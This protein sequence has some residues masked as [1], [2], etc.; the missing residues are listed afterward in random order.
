MP[1]KKVDPEETRTLHVTTKREE[2]RITIPASCKVTFGPIFTS[3][4]RRNNSYSE[5]GAPTALRIYEA[6][7]KQRAVF[8]DV[9]TFRDLSY[10]L[11]RKVA[12][13]KERAVWE[14]DGRGFRQERSGTRVDKWLPAGP[15]EEEGDED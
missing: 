11:E 10:P 6:N 13:V 9:L 14:D 2:F 5:G 15:Q 7:D 3:S 8:T 4:T 1:A 12:A